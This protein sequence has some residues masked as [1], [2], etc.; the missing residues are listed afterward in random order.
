MMNPTW[1]G[2]DVRLHTQ[3]NQQM[4]HH[5][6]PKQD[7]FLGTSSPSTNNTYKQGKQLSS[8]SS[9]SS[10]IHQATNHQNHHQHLSS[11]SMNPSFPRTNPFSERYKM[12]CDS[13]NNSNSN[14]SCALSLLSSPPL[15]VVSSQ[16][17]D[18]HHHH[19]HQMVNNTT[20]SSFMQPLGLSL[21]DHSL[22]SVDHVLGPNDQTGH[23]S[24][25][26]NMGSNESHSQGN[27]N[28]APPPLYPFQ[29]D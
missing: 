9:S 8:S 25:I 14:A 18:H 5:L 10:F 6:V 27:D 21:H 7:L 16:T 26:Y 3:H 22:G 15:P 19:Q 2:T 13:N 23:C 12:I 24:S 28:D 11:P 29:W 20:H 17:H 1:G 4:H